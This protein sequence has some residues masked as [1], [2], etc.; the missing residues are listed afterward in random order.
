M[1]T[2]KD[3]LAS[4]T[5]PEPGDLHLVGDAAHLL[6]GCTRCHAV[7]ALFMFRP[8]T[9]WSAAYYCEACIRSCIG[10]G[11][12][13]CSRVAGEVVKHPGT[14]PVTEGHRLLISPFVA[15]LPDGSKVNLPAGTVLREGEALIIKPLGVA[16]AAFLAWYDETHSGGLGGDAYEHRER[17]AREAFCAHLEAAEKAVHPPQVVTGSK[18][19]SDAPG[20]AKAAGWIT[21]LDARGQPAKIEMVGPLGGIVSLEPPFT[22]LVPADEPT[23]PGAIITGVMGS[24]KC[25]GPLDVCAV[26]APGLV[27]RDGTFKGSTQTEDEPDP[28]PLDRHQAAFAL[29]AA[30]FPEDKIVEAIE[31]ARGMVAVYVEPTH[32]APA[33]VERARRAFQILRAYVAYLDLP[34]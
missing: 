6:E 14:C 27:N 18:W 31:N 8:P 9:T 33:E 12:E 10:S 29:R 20:T 1:S 17:A 30:G 21:G 5:I 13:M 7:A 4:K 26:C 2:P 28:T 24:C 19:V 25:T 11:C 16:E 23:I 15:T 32:L 34:F 22:K 3:P